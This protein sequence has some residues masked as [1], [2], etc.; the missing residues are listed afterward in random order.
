MFYVYAYLRE[1]FSPYYIGKGSG[2][3][4]FVKCNGEIRPPR[5]KRRIVILQNNLPEDL[6]F[7][8]ESKLIKFFGRK[9][10]GTGILRNKSEGG[11]GNSGWRASDEQKNN[12]YMKLPE[13]RKIQSERSSGKNNPMYGKGLFGEGNP[14]FGKKRTLQWR[15]SMSGENN[16]MFGKLG[17]D[18]PASKQCHTPLGWFSSI[19]EAAKAHNVNEC[20]IR[21]RILNKCEL[22]KEYYK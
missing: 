3:R 1:D 5:D 21:R 15:E 20:T 2:N 12:H 19:V 6:A 4:A 8:Y 7:D 17:G 22:Y 9:D 10:I 18:S 11:K 16:P 14:M 13:W